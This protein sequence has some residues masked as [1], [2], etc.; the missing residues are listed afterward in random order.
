MVSEGRAALTR[1]RE[2]ADD[3]VARFDVPEWLTA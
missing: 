3:I 1:R 2:T